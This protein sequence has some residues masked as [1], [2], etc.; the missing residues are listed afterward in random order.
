ML[1][2]ISASPDDFEL[3]FVANATAGIKLVADAFRDND[4]GFWYGYHKDAHTSIV[5]ARELATQGHRCFWTDDEVDT[6]ISNGCSAE[7]DNDSALKLFAYPGQSNLTGRRL[8]H[9]WPNLLRERSAE[10]RG[11]VYT[12]FDAAALVTTSPLDFSHASTAPDYTVLSFYKIFGFPDLAALIVRKDS[13]T[14]LLRRK[15]FGGGAVDLVSCGQEQWHIKKQH[16]IHEQLEDGTLPIH[17]IVALDHAFAAQTRLFG[18]MQRISSHT[19]FLTRIL[20]ESLSRLRHANGRQV[21]TF[22]PSTV[23]PREKAKHGPV[24]AFNMRNSQGAWISNAEVEKLANTKDIHFRIGGHCNPAGTASYL[25]LAPWELQRNFSAGYRCGGEDD[26]VA[27]K[28][29]GTIRVSLGAMSTTRDV[30]AFVEFLREFFVD[31]TVHSET[32]SA[33]DDTEPSDFYIEALNVYP[34]KSCGAWPVPSATVWD[35]K[36]EGLVWDREWC[37]VHQGNHEALSQKRFPKMALIRPFLRFEEGSLEITYCGP[38]LPNV[39]NTIKVPLSQDPSVFR[40]QHK[41]SANYRVCN[42]TIKPRVYASSTVAKFFTDILGTSCTLARFS[43]EGP[44]VRYA[45]AHLQGHQLVRPKTSSILRPIQ[46]SN[47]SPILVISRSSVDSLNETIKSSFKA[48]KAAHASVFRANIVLAER[49]RS[50]P[51]IIQTSTHPYIEDHWSSL[52]FTSTDSGRQGV[53]EAGVAYGEQAPVA[54]LDLLGSC[55]RCQM[56]CID[57]TTG[58]K[59]PE[60]FSTLAKTRRIDG[61]VWFGVHAV[62]KDGISHGR[63]MV[64]MKAT[65]SKDSDA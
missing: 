43:K 27:G 50:N 19:S 5:G 47:E 20:Q 63:V 55:R 31:R 46:M 33:P 35:I 45:K 30:N 4:N 52:T 49:P 22:Y 34:I 9:P 11:K 7:K 26:I 12:I 3:V 29:T 56:V 18:S 23:S 39:P 8:L 17:T 14:P 65:G 60:P 2:F 44:S 25:G 16:T 48:G 40:E 42:E 58:E 24:I 10:E 61:K 54:E 53:T 59:N 37:L 64:G 1:D 32:N 13:A 41:T 38:T 15:Y 51:R 6:W 36:R 28:P 62:L 21:C 57:Q